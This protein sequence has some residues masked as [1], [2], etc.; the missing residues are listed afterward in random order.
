MVHGP[1]FYIQFSF[2]IIYIRVF[3]LVK[4]EVKICHISF[5]QYTTPVSVGFDCHA[6]VIT[7]GCSNV[8]I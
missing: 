7:T 6:V 4:D 3:S 1:S 5:P 8:K 2:N